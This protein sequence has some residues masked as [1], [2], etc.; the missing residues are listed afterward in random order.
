MVLVSS[1]NLEAALDAPN[2]IVEDE[3]DELERNMNFW[4]PE[5]VYIRIYIRSQG[6]RRYIGSAVLLNEM[7]VVRIWESQ[8]Q[9]ETF[10][11]V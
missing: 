2:V 6:T 9:K 7:A 10:P 3:P 4:F 11:L 5:N 8:K 1:F